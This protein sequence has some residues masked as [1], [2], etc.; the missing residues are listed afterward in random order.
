MES[1]EVMEFYDFISRPKN[2]WNLGVGY[3]KSWTDNVDCLA[4]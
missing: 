2:S 1:W 4:K 3:G